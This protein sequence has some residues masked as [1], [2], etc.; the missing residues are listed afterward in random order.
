LNQQ[1][2]LLEKRK[3]VA[4]DCIDLITDIRELDLSLK[5]AQKAIDNNE[6]ET[7]SHFLGKVI[8]L[9]QAIQPRL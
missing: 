3:S 5:Q 9:I 6:V 1:I 2:N 4:T 8:S 7:A